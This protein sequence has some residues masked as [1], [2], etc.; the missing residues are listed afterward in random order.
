MYSYM[1]TNAGGIDSSNSA[2]Q[3]L[4]FTFRAGFTRKLLSGP[5]APLAWTTLAS[6]VGLCSS[7]ERQWWLIQK[8]TRLFCRAEPHQWSPVW[9]IAR[10]EAELLPWRAPLEE[11]RESLDVCIVSALVS[12]LSPSSS[13]MNG[14]TR[15][16]E[17]SPMGTDFEVG[18]SVLKWRLCDS[19]AG[20]RN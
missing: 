18:K 13:W 6:L 4:C 12:K 11:H 16:T 8:I 19:H 10:G 9:P 5:W 3:A 14:E 20:V 17:G 2:L 7:S 1:L 15:S